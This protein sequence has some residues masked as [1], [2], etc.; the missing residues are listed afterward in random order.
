MTRAFAVLAAAMAGGAS[1]GAAAQ[2]P[3]A[4]PQSPTFATPVRIQA[5]DKH[6]GEGRLYPSPVFHDVDG[7]GRLDI[8]VGDLPGALTYAPRMPGDGP[9]RFGKEQPLLGAGNKP[10]KF[11]N[12]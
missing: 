7:D 8:V 3:A 11:H 10:I 5:G 6:L 2:Q 4:P 12:W 1:L 9:P